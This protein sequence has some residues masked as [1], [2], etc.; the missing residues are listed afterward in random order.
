MHADHSRKLAR[1]GYATIVLSLFASSAIADPV[2]MSGGWVA[3]FSPS[4]KVAADSGTTVF[5]LQGSY[6]LSGAGLGEVYF[7]ATCVGMETAT[8]AADGKALTSGAGRCELKEPNGDMLLAG[9]ETMYDGFKLKIEGGTGK[10]ASARGAI[11]SKETFTFESERV[12][13][14]FSNATGDLVLR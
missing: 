10:W 12:L 8:K 14:G 9:M 4:M 11:V 6:K 7:L 3:D 13:K 1:A 2:V 5:E